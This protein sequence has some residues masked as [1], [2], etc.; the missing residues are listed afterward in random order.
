MQRRRDVLIRRAHE[1]DVHDALRIYNGHIDGDEIAAERECEEMM[2]YAGV[3][4]ECEGDMRY[5]TA[6]AE[7]A[8]LPR[9]VADFVDNYMRETVFNREHGLDVVAVDGLQ[10]VV[11]ENWNP[12]ERLKKGTCLNN[13]AY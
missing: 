6:H 2:K 1:Q 3:V 5:M 12:V 11:D 7:A 4:R 9:A 10:R 13:I 8:A